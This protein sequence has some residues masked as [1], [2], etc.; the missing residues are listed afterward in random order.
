MSR[1]EWVACLGAGLGLLAARRAPEWLAA[2][3]GWADLAVHEPASARYLFGLLVLPLPFVGA[4]LAGALLNFVEVHG[5]AAPQRRRR[6]PLPRYPF[7]PQRTQLVIGETHQQDGTR[8]EQPGW[9]VL[10]EKG[11]YT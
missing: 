9:L 5:V 1:R 7:H 10:P 4:V 3:N 11:M 2:A 6:R 8:S